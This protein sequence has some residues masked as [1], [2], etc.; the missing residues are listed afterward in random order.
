MRSWGLWFGYQL[1]GNQTRLRVACWH[2]V[3]VLVGALCS[4]SVPRDA[5][6]ASPCLPRVLTLVKLLGGTA[7]TALAPL[8]L[9]IH[10][11]WCLSLG[12]NWVQWVKRIS[13]L[14]ETAR[15]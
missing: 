10:V 15:A 2:P 11:I 9:L 3:L 5:L 6:V 1:K 4:L 8:H 14:E 7:G 12:W 13:R